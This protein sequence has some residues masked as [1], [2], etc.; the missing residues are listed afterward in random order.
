VYEI[1]CLC[2]QL[3]VAIKTSEQARARSDYFKRAEANFKRL[4]GSARRPSKWHLLHGEFLA[5]LGR[6]SEADECFADSY[7]VT[8]QADMSL[9]FYFF[10]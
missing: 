10:R 6:N 4:A 3:V 8:D 5:A 9:S 1:A 7:A 2:P